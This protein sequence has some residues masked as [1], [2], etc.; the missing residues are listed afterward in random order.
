VRRSPASGRYLL[1]QDLI[2]L[3]DRRGT[4]F[5]RMTEIRKVM[6]TLCAETLWP[7]VVS[8]PQGLRMVVWETTDRETPLRFEQFAAGFDVPRLESASGLAFVAHL[9]T[10]ERDRL[11]DRLAEST[12]PFA[13]LARSRGRCLASLR[14]YRREGYAMTTHPPFALR[15]RRK[16]RR[17]SALDAVSGFTTSLAVPVL[18]G[19]RPVACLAIRYI[20]SAMTRAT[21]A[22]RYVPRLKQ[23]A[24][25]I[26]ALVASHTP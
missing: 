20:D 2:A 4:D 16:P 22:R 8:G 13:E 23:A 14:A 15:I 5:E 18:V 11:L 17:D 26:S 3:I 25:Q 24:Q 19:G 6:R 9:P 1:S 21:A 7:V 10:E 12:E